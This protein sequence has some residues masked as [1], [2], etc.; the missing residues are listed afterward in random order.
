MQILHDDTKVTTC[1][2]PIPVL[3]S[4]QYSAP[5]QPTHAHSMQHSYFTPF[6]HSILHSTPA[7]S[8][9]FYVVLHSILVL[10]FVLYP[11][12]S[13]LV[14]HST[15]F[16]YLIPV[17]HSSTSVQPQFSS[18]ALYTMSGHILF[19]AVLTLLVGVSY[20]V[21]GRSTGAAAGACT[22]LAPDPSAHGAQPETTPVEYTV[23]ISALSDGSGGW[24]YTPG[25]TY[26]R[27]HLFHM[28]CAQQLSQRKATSFL[29]LLQTL[30]IP[31][32]C[33]VLH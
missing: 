30:R 26:P 6:G 10:H 15:P 29:C 8:T 9:S 33:C 24:S 2:V 17:L 1:M 25:Q 14:L 4:I 28:I 31:N 20:V 32:T 12:H 5:F 19:S 23:N 13:T 18:I 11:F 7:Y 16:H 21:E 27:K 3:Y 22:T